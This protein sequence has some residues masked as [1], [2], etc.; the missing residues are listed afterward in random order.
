M[1][2]VDLWLVI[3]KVTMEYLPEKRGTPELQKTKTTELRKLKRTKRKTH[4]PQVPH[5]A[6]SCV[7]C[8]SRVAD[9]VP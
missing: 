7:H 1:E 9:S 6:A 5:A 4:S 8:Y 2:L 3:G